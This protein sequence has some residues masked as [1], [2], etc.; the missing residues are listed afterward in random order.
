MAAGAGSCSRCG[1]KKKRP[2]EPTISSAIQSNV[3]ANQAAD[4]RSKHDRHYRRTGREINKFCCRNRAERTSIGRI[5]HGAEE[6]QIEARV[7]NKVQRQQGPS[8]R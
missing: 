2:T 7:N 5:A 1:V 3:V 8:G 6:E 4:T